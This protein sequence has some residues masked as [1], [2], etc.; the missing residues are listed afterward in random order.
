MVQ[1]ASKLID[2]DISGMNLQH[3]VKILQWPLAKSETLQSIHLSDNNIPKAI[4][5]NLLMAFG[6]KS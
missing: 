3:S 1:T 2:L 6:I 5:K 4:E